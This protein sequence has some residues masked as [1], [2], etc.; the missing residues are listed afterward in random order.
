MQK[1]KEMAGQQTSSK[2]TRE[3]EGSVISSAASTEFYESITRVVSVE[4]R[5]KEGP[6]GAMIR[7]ATGNLA[8]VRV[9]AWEILY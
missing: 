2:R 6:L 3:L 5:G 1:E 8:I 9:P 7:T 4:K